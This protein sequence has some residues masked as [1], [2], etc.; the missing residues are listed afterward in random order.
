MSNSAASDVGQR[1]TPR[2]VWRKR[3]QESSPLGKYARRGGLRVAAIVTFPLLQGSPADSRRSGMTSGSILAARRLSA[4]PKCQH[5]LCS[6][7]RQCAPPQPNI[8]VIRVGTAR[9]MTEPT[10]RKQVVTG[11][12]GGSDERPDRRHRPAAPHSMDHL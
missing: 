3:S 2:C 10:I 8:V 6:P 12:I 1:L 7:Q 9:D 11:L 4:T 5:C